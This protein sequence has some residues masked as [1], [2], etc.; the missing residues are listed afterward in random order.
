MD[1]DP[2]FRCSASSV[3]AGRRLRLFAA[4]NCSTSGIQGA[5]AI[6]WQAVRCAIVLPVSNSVTAGMG[7]GQGYVKVRLIVRAVGVNA[8]A[9]GAKATCVACRARAGGLRRG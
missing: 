1:I 3:S 7:H 4:R 8:S 2:L 5:G 9:T 6:C